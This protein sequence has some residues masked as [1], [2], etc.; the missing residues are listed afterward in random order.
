MITNRATARLRGRA[1]LLA[2]FVMALAAGAWGGSA[3][4]QTQEP[5]W[6]NSTPLTAITPFALFQ[7]STLSG[8][9]NT[10]TATEV[11]VVTSSGTTIYKQVTAQFQVDSAGNLVLTPGF[12]KVVNAP[13]PPFAAFKAGTFVGPGTL[14]NGKFFIVVGG[15][16]V[17]SGGTTWSSIAA[18]GSAPGTYPSSASWFDGPIANNPV[19]ARLNKQGITS[20]ALSYGVANGGSSAPCCNWLAGTLIGVSQAGNNLTFYSF[21]NGTIDHNAPIDAISYTLAPAP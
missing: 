14:G 10:I 18:T 17:S 3:R 19:A 8:S 21:S 12:P 20:T 1:L 9:G 7:F 2:A 15:P 13:I 6:E 16:A 4:A 11:P 5:D